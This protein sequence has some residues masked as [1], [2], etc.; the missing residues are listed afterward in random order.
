MLARGVQ[1]YPDSMNMLDQQCTALLGGQIGGGGEELRAGVGGEWRSPR[2]ERFAEKDFSTI[3][4]STFWS[5]SA[6][7][8]T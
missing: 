4:F 2:Y 8:L 3:D 1:R 5:T 6:S 7:F